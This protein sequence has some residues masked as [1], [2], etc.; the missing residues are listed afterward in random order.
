MILNIILIIV[1]VATAI[2]A[3]IAIKSFSFIVIVI[4][5]SESITM[6][7]SIE[8]KLATIETNFKKEIDFMENIIKVLLAEK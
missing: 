8:I 7:S 3:T 1:A 4:I 5:T 2:E 6:V